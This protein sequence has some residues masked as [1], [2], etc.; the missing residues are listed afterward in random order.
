[1]DYLSRVRMSTAARYLNQ[2]D[3]KVNEIS[4]MVGYDNPNYFSSQF[5]RYLG[6]SPVE[7]RRRSRCR[8]QD[9]EEK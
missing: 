1:M 3:M 8:K 6:E 7:Y 5:K 9:P 2:T 4:L